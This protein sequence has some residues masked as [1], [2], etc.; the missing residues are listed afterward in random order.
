MHRPGAPVT[1]ALEPMPATPPHHRMLSDARAIL[2]H[3]TGLPYRPPQ[4]FGRFPSVEAEAAAIRASQEAWA[5]F[6]SVSRAWREP[7]KTVA[8]IVKRLE[9]DT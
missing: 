2:R 4:V 6:H 8:E 9:E 1:T 7:L 3:L 5:A